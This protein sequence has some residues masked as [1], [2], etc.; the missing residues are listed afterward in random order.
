V[1]RR[2]DVNNSMAVALSARIARLEREVSRLVA[3]SEDDHDVLRTTRDALTVLRQRLSAVQ[4]RRELRALRGSAV[5]P[6][7]RVGPAVRAVE[8]GPE[9]VGLVYVWVQ[10]VKIA[11]DL[12]VASP[13]H[14]R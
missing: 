1:G 4:D 10:P 6:A 11:E 2:G 8:A 9:S 14:D 3:G 13:A 12:V 7:L 5:A